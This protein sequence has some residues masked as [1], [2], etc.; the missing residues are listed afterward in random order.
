MQV[1][2]HGEKRLRKRFGVPKRSVR[3]LAVAALKEGK[4]PDELDGRL[5]K[6]LKRKIKPGPNRQARLYRGYVFLFANE[7]LI[8]VWQLPGS[9]R[10]QMK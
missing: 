7:N 2:D 8:T 1:S 10:R 9:L 5:A 3:R 6:Y 4:T